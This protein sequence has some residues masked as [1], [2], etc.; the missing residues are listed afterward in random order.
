MSRPLLIAC[1]SRDVRNRSAISAIVPRSLDLRS[2]RSELECS[3]RASTLRG[4]VLRL[5]M[6]DYYQYM[7]GSRIL[8]LVGV[9]IGHDGINV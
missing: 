2:L 3:L 8:P 7:F 1:C 5:P 4:T 6:Q 9:K